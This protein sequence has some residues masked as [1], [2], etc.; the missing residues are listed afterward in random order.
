[1]SNTFVTSSDVSVVVFS[2][3][4]LCALQDLSAQPDMAGHCLR[5]AIEGGG[6][7]GFAYYFEM[8]Q[9]P[10]DDDLSLFLDL[11]NHTLFQVVIDPFSLPYLKGAQ[12]DYAMDLQG[13]SFVVSNPNAKTTCGCGRSF[14]ADVSDTLVAEAT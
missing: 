13:A 6:C 11:P 1:M 10:L 4:A 14:S 5:M 8:T 9:Q 3:Q 2:Q 7:S 12:V